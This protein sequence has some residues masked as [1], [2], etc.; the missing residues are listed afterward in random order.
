MAVG[1]LH[2]QWS[3]SDVPRAP[4][5]VPDCGLGRSGP[6][7]IMAVIGAWIIDTGS[8]VAGSG[9]IIVRANGPV[10]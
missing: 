7:T 8:P 1:C 3:V 9:T 2:P 4:V 6:P 5:F 10:K